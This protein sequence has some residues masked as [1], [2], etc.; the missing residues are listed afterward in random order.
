MAPTILCFPTPSPVAPMSSSVRSRILSAIFLFVASSSSL[1]CPIQR[2]ISQCSLRATASQGRRSQESPLLQAG[3]G[4][5][6]PG[7][8]SHRGLSH[9][10]P[11]KGF[12]TPQKAG[13]TA[14]HTLSSSPSPSLPPFTS[15]LPYEAVSVASVFT[16]FVTMR[17]VP[18]NSTDWSITRA[19]K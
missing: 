1:L 2:S 17:N 9:A 5:S 14:E 8:S 19:S 13:E 3:D 6:L 11:N 4:V 10:A 16:T 15:S 12:H 7:P 18:S